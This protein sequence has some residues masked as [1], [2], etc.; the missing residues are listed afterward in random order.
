MGGSVTERVT[1]WEP[2][3]TMAFEMSDHPW[4]LKDVRFRISLAPD[5]SGTRMLQDTEYV[6]TGDEAGAAD[7]RSQWDHGVSAV[8]AAFKR[9]V[10]VLTRV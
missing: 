3:Q 10:E 4:P 8:I 5:G 1:G 2:E 9:H 6:F 7:V